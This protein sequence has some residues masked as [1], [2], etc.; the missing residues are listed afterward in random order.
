MALEALYCLN[1]YCIT[2][3]SPDL[4]STFR[5]TNL[6]AV[7]LQQ[8]KKCLQLKK[9]NYCNGKLESRLLTTLLQGIVKQKSINI[10]K[11]WWACFWVRSNGSSSKYL[12]EKRAFCRL[13]NDNYWCSTVPLSPVL[14]YCIL[15]SLLQCFSLIY[16][17]NREDLYSTELQNTLK[18]RH[19]T[20][21]LLFA[22]VSSRLASSQL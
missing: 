2:T 20:N 18:W 14:F 9:D 4:I 10:Q 6:W 21:Q 5:P 8:N 12:T 22:V 7:S 15:F 16:Q 11:A 13:I 19:G 3:T 1:P 17:F